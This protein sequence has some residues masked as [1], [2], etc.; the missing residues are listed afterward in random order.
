MWHHILEPG[1]SN[2]LSNFHWPFL[3]L[4]SVVEGTHTVGGQDGEMSVQCMSTGMMATLSFKPGPE[5]LV[6]GSVEQQMKPGA[7]AS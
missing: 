2:N 4:S 3:Y 5:A 6:E 7:C 1:A